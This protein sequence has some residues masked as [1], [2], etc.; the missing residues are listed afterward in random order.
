VSPQLYAMRPKVGTRRERR[1]TPRN[2][3]LKSTA[4]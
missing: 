3:W 4:E 1:R 2:H